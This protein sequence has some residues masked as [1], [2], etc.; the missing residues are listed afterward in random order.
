MIIKKTIGEEISGLR[1]D[2]AIS[3]LCDQVSRSEA[4]RII[5]IYERVFQRRKR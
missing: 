4:R 2:E 5:A 1:L 3:L